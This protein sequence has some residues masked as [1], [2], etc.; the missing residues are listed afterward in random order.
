M[1][2]DDARLQFSRPGRVCLMIWC[3]AFLALIACTCILYWDLES[4]GKYDEAEAL[5][6]RGLDICERALGPDHPDV[7]T[8]LNN[9][10]ELLEKQV[11]D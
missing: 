8:S 7:A 1:A 11:R 10:A 9:L 6:R 5:H 3:S 4:Q 2:S